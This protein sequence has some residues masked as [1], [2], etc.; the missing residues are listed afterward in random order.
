MPVEPDPRFRLKPSLFPQPLELEL[1]EE[2]M[3]RRQR[4]ARETGF[5]LSELVHNLVRR[6]LNA[7]ARES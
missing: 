6:Q 1:P 3:E 2:F 4:M 5:A 7:N